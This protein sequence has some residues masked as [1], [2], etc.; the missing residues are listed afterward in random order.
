MLEYSTE[1]LL[2]LRCY[3][4]IY[5]LRMIIGLIIMKEYMYIVNPNLEIV[6]IPYSLDKPKTF[7]FVKFS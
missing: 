3:E 7:L 2:L 6:A 5:F 4:S 1:R